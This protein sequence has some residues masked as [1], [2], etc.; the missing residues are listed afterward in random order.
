[1]AGVE[2][3]K[4]AA[5][6]NGWTE[7]RRVHGARAKLVTGTHSKMT[8]SMGDLYQTL[9]NK[10][11]NAGTGDFPTGGHELSGVV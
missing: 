10:V 6:P 3:A 2:C 7:R 5:D 9:A 1:M 4:G 11:M 8:G